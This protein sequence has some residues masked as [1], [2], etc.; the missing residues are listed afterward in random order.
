[1]FLESVRL[2]RLLG[3]LI[4]EQTTRRAVQLPL[5]KKMARPSRPATQAEP[6]RVQALANVARLLKLCRALRSLR[7]E[8]R[9][10]AHRLIGVIEGIAHR[11]QPLP[12]L[13]QAERAVHSHR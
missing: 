10:I 4:E 6:G 9:V 8:V 3:A 13:L 7:P 12:L 2:N 5:G 11:L 1:M